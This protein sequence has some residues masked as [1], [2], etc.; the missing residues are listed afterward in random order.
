MEKESSLFDQNFKIKQSVESK[1]ADESAKREIQ[2]GSV[3][4]HSKDLID[5]FV[6][7]YEKRSAHNRVLRIIFFSLS[8]LVLFAIV[9]VFAVVAIL[10]AMKETI[11]VEAVIAIIGS[12]ATMLTSVLVLPKMVGR[13]L[14]PDKEDSEILQFVRD[15]NN[16]ENESITQRSI[17]IR[18]GESKK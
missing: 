3:K 8:F 13:N 2:S 10:A 17:T 18:D 12:G 11:N 7:H 4:E 14:F 6:A 16:A 9:A 15:M 1:D 5:K